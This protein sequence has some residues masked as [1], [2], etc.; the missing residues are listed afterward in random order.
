MQWM[1]FHERL[2]RYGEDLIVKPIIGVTSAVDE[3]SGVDRIQL[4]RSYI[5]SVEA[6]GGI[7][8]VL[9]VSSR[10]DGTADV[11]ERVDGVLLTGGIDID[12]SFFGEE[13]HPKIGSIDLDWDNH[14]IAVARHCLSAKIPVLGICRG[15][16]V[17]NVA[18]GGSLYQ[19]ISSLVPK[20]IKHTLK[21]PRWQP[22][23]NISIQKGSVLEG[24]LGVSILS[25]NSFHHQSVARPGS[26]FSV[27]AWA[28]D[29]VVE[30]IESSAHPFAVGV[31]WHPEGMWERYEV[32]KR[33]FQAL[34]LAASGYASKRAL[35]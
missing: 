30:G 12:P 18:A 19:D 27:S 6:A 17:L 7:P 32:H 3:E 24:V 10:I 22:C 13:P 28:V 31:Q 29:G 11:L 20:A 14:D 21:A 2:I 1:H 34:V 16:Q 23:H 8:V 4:N 9:P 26:G 35:K 33:V 15:C 5:Y 25:V